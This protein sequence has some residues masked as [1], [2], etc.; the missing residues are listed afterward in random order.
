MSRPVVAVTIPLR[1]EDRA[2]PEVVME[3]GYQRGLEISEVTALPISPA[4]TVAGAREKIGLAD[5]LLMTGGEDVNP[6]RYGEDPNGVRNVSFERD[7]IEFAVLEKALELGLPVLSIC[8]GMQLLNVFMGGSLYQDLPEQW[9]GKVDIDHDCRSIYDRPVHTIRVE[10]SQ[11]LEGVFQEPAFSPNSSHHQ[12]IRE[13]GDGLTPV[14]WAE[15]GLVEAV[16]YRNGVWAAG[17]QWH[18]ERML[19]EDSG[20][21]KRLFRLFGHQLRQ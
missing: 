1:S 4:D 10:A 16:E 20:T 2:I 14:C 18:P 19:G 15:D 21:H 9:E 13:L 11:L 5:G 12:G 6:A 3:A 8:R 17:V 7:E